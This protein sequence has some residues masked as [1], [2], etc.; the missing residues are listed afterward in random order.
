[1]TSQRSN[2][3]V[4][5]VGLQDWVTAYHSLLSESAD[6]LDSPGG[7]LLEAYAMDLYPQCI[8]LMFAFSLPPD[9][10]INENERPSQCDRPD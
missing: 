7:P 1:M 2:A 8:S 5:N 9:A 3:G 6:L 4:T 10:C